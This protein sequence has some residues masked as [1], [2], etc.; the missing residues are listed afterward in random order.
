MDMGEKKATLIYLFLKRLTFVNNNCN[1]FVRSGL[2]LKAFSCYKIP[3]DMAGLVVFEGNLS[4]VVNVI[5]T[6]Q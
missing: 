1:S 2:P 6:S 3:K 4:W 5:K